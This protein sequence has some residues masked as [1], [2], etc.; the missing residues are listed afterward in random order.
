MFVQCIGSGDAFGSGGR[1]NS[2]YYIKCSQAK[3]LMDCGGT[4]LVGLKKF[5]IPVDDLDAV[6]ISHLHGDHFG[7]LPYILCELLVSGK[8]KKPL[9]IIGPEDTEARTKEALNCFYPGIPIRPGSP[10]RFVTYIAEEVLNLNS[11]K[12][13]PYTAIHSSKTNPHCF[14]IEGDGKVLAY[15]GD[16]GWTDNLLTIS[17]HADLFICEGSFYEIPFK[18]HIRIKDLLG[19]LDQITAKKIVITHV[20]EEV[21]RNIERIPLTIAEDGMILMDE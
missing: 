20:G 19:K 17:E 2:A 18:Q 4:T 21:L 5:N 1:F 10:V 8:R 13:T 9:T 3:L 6:L 16:S 14:R 11:I 7:G 15:S 12:I